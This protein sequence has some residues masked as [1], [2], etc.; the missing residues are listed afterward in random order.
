MKGRYD[1]EQRESAKGRHGGEEMKLR[2]PLV[3][4]VVA[5]ITAIVLENQWSPP[6]WMS[7]S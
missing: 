7:K 2:T 5:R 4:T 1:G 6:W 3:G